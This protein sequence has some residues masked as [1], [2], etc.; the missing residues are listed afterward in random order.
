MAKYKLDPVW[1]ERYG[2]EP[3]Y[4]EIF[5][6]YGQ[7][8]PKPILLLDPKYPIEE[9]C[10]FRNAKRKN[11]CEILKDAYCQYGKCSFYKNREEESNGRRMGRPEIPV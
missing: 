3:T 7:P 10:Q 4:E 8:V 11:G 5:R 9:T 6:F 2:H 1:A